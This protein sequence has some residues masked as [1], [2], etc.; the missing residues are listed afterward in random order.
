MYSA[1]GISASPKDQLG[2]RF[3]SVFGGKDNGWH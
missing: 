3:I 2:R 1:V